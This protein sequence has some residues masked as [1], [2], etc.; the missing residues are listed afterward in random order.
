M[1][2]L[3]AKL[4]EKLIPSDNLPPITLII[5]EGYFLFILLECVSNK[6]YSDVEEFWESK[7]IIEKYCY[8]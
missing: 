2:S 4:S 1:I 3:R 5:I 8:F 6:L 7:S